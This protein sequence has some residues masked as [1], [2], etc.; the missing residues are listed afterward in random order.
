MANHPQIMQ[1]AA[2]SVNPATGEWIERFEF[3]TDAEIET[4]LASSFEGFQRWRKTAMDERVAIFRRMAGVLRANAQVFAET[5]T[6]EM[7]KVLKE[8]KDE[9][10]KCARECEWYS[11]HGP[12]MVMDEPAPMEGSTAYVSYLPTGPIL[13]VM[14]WNF[15]F[16]QPMR[17]AVPILLGGNTMVLKPA[18]NVMRCAIH[19]QSAWKESGLPD[20]AFTVLNATNK[21]TEQ[22][23]ADRRIAAVTV[24]GSP[25]AGAA[26]AAAA[27][28]ALKKSVLELGG[29]DP[30]IVLAD[31]DIG[32]AVEAGIR[33]RYSNA[34]QVCIS[35]KRF[36]LESPIAKEFTKQ[37][38]QAVYTLKTGDPMEEET[39]LGPIARDDLREALHKQVQ[40]TIAAGATLLT[41]GHKLS[42]KGFFYEPTVLS[43]VQP[44]M[45]AFQ[46]ET[47]GPVAAMTIARDAEQAIELAN[48][49]VYGLSG[50][51]WS[52]NE[53]RARELARRLE[54]GG[55]FINGFS[56]S[57]P[58]VPIGGVKNSGYGRELS[59]FG[60]REFLN[61]QTVW[62]NRP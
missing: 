4:I 7:G 29:S 16:W 59:Y 27:G 61:V 14:P 26:V 19:L 25:R 45:T 2:E 48:D 47:F 9:V 33:A 53:K 8:A 56:A 10:E 41:G 32:R 20:G 42:G 13:A 31:A 17:A 55:V 23:I 30:F 57:D 52:G 1:E 39:K 49:S 21:H 51:L 11:E 12:K 15:P 24:T 35:A 43:N 6:R 5:I 50:N 37:F 28:K 18:P 54:T 22:V 44:G 36:I 58:R 40:D 62:L 46:E 60:P 3:Q 34:G 38:L